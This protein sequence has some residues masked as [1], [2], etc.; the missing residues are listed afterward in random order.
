[1]LSDDT[2]TIFTL[3]AIRNRGDRGEQKRLNKN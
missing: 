1:M 2:Y 3:K